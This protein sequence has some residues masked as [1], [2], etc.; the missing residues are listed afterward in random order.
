MA[1]VAASAVVTQP[2][3]AHRPSLR[4]VVSP[5][6]RRRTGVIVLVGIVLLALGLVGARILVQVEAVHLQEL[7]ASLQRAQYLE[8]S[9]AVQVAG[10]EAP[11]RVESYAMTHL[12]LQAPSYVD[13]VPGRSLSGSVALPQPGA[14]P[15]V[16]PLPAGVVQRGS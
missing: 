2:V 7:Q 1:R 13:V 15:G 6:P 12:G 8:R 3:G 4:L 5:P 11:S 14:A 10:L 16:V 9:L